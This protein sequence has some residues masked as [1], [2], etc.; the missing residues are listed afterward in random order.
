MRWAG[1]GGFG[2]TSYAV[3]LPE[4]GLTVRIGGALAARVSL[5]PRPGWNEFRFKIPAS[6]VRENRTRLDIS[7]RYASFYYWFYQ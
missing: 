4:E 2:S 5:R 6:L 7:G 1:A 3:A